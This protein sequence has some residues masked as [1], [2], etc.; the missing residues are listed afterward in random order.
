MS[1]FIT[2]TYLSYGSRNNLHKVLAAE[3]RHYFHATFLLVPHFDGKILAHLN[4]TNH[5]SL[6]V[7]VCSLG[8]EKLLSISR[9]L[10]GSI[11]LMG[12]K[13]AKFVSE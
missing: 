12:Q 1:R 2:I 10:V 11:A 4:E 5:D 7:V 6:A 8:V 9:Q 13:M 3:V